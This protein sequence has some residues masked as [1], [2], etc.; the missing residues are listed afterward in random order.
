MKKVSILLLSLVSSLSMAVS[1]HPCSPTVTGTPVKIYCEAGVYDVSIVIN[2]LKSPA[3]A[4]CTGQNFF[5]RRTANVTIKSTI[6]KEVVY[7]ADIPHELFS[8]TVSPKVTFTSEVPN[9]VLEK[10]VTPA[11]RF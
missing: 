7:A 4:F 3:S 10:C 2:S 11:A 1:T 5:E 8:Y 9:M 6:S